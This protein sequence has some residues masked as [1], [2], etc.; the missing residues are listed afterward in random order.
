MLRGL[1]T[2][3]RLSNYEE[4][5]SFW[6]GRRVW[7]RGWVILWGWLSRCSSRSITRI[8]WVTRWRTIS[9]TFRTRN[10][11]HQKLWISSRC[12][13]R[14]S[15]WWVCESKK[16]VV[17]LTKLTNWASNNRLQ[18]NNLHLSLIQINLNDH[19]KAHITKASLLLT[20]GTKNKAIP[21][22][23]RKQ[24]LRMKNFRLA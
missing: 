2:G 18:R 16:K 9:L 24:L 8:P 3:L 10:M 5:W 4:R 6:R 19:H 21:V 20:G 22:L 15:L 1:T 12:L 13:H 23:K 14:S 17:I 7:F 11:K